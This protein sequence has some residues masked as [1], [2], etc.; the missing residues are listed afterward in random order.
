MCGVFSNIVSNSFYATLVITMYYYQMIYEMK[1]NEMKLWHWSRIL[2][3]KWKWKCEKKENWDRSTAFTDRIYCTEFT[4]CLTFN[5]Q[6]LDDP[7]DSKNHPIYYNTNPLKISKTFEITMKDLPFILLSF[8]IW[9]VFFSTAANEIK[10]N[11]IY[12][13]FHHKICIF[14]FYLKSLHFTSD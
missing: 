1:W 10:T 5:V 13:F 14:I 11:I 8:W 6:P 2:M 4:K 3:L 12:F 9:C 7:S